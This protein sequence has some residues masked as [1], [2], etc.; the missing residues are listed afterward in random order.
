[1]QHAAIGGELRRGLFLRRARDLLAPAVGQIHHKHITMQDEGRMP[2]RMV[3]YRRTIRLRHGG[4]IQL[5]ALPAG[6]IDAIHIL[7]RATVALE[8]VIDATAVH[9]PVR[10]FHRLTDPVRVG[11]DGFQIQRAAGR[12]RGG[13]GGQHGKSD[14][15]GKQQSAHE[16]VSR[17]GNDEKN[18]HSRARPPRMPTRARSQGRRGCTQGSVALR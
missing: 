13:C 4:R 12:W 2:V 18:Q 16:S 15:S 3:V 7:D 6:R 17:E 5:H 14:E 11:H 1:L 8:R 9:A 10:H